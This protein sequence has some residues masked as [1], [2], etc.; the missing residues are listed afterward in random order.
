MQVIPVINCPD[1]DT[2]KARIEIAQEFLCDHG[3]ENRTA[4]PEGWVHIDVADG[5]FTAG[6]ATWRNPA[7]LKSF[8]RDQ[9]LK[10]EAHLMLTE[11]ELA[12]EEWLDAGVNRVIVHLETVTAIDTVVNICES[13][14]VEV[15][16]AIAPQTPAEKAFPYLSIVKGCQ[17]LAVQPGLPGQTMAA[18]SLEKIR[19]IRE[20][21]PQLPIEA[22][23]GVTAET[24]GQYKSAGATQVV[25]GSAIF[26]AEDS[27][28]A[29]R[30]LVRAGE[31][32]FL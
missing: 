11:P 29:Y 21:F 6:Y 31:S 2:V 32:L 3:S 8:K 27:A 28:A 4:A 22:D 5:G 25:A 24:I 9:H 12:L 18:G 15:W 14:N 7:D 13:H 16:L 1:F 23:G 20:A 17:V 26:N 30:T 10:I 19:A